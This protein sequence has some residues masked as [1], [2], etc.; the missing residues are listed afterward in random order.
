MQPPKTMNTTDISFPRAPASCSMS[1]QSTW[2]KTATPVPANIDQ[3]DTKETIKL[4]RI[5][6]LIPIPPSET[7][8]PSDPE[9]GSVR[10]CMSLN[11]PY[12][13]GCRECCGDSISLRKCEMASRFQLILIG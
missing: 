12:F 5:A 8:S 4:L 13:W 7:N 1:G 10:E 9:G 3:K 11:V 6:P 2:T